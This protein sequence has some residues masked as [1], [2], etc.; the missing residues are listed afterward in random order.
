MATDKA[1]A[2][3]EPTIDVLVAKRKSVDVD[4]RLYGPGSKLTL[5]LSEA[6]SLYDKGFVVEPDEVDADVSTEGALKIESQ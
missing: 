6:K 3:Q 2:E 5:P 4:G 1:K